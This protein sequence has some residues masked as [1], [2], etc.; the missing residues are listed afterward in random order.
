MS[1]ASL[2]FRPH[3][4]WKLSR[5]SRQLGK[6]RQQRYR[7]LLVEP[8]EDRRLLALSVWDGMPD[9]GGAPANA[10]WTTAANWVG[11]VAPSPGND[12]VFPADALVLN[13]VNDFAAGTPFGEILIRG[14]GY[15]LAGNRIG[16]L[17]G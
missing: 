17:A 5:R 8:L 7:R 4:A 13:A 10:N 15:T 1:S 16:L 12:L 9:S 6:D 2:S 14:S 11:D 3:P